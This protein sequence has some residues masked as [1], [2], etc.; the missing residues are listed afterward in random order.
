MVL[1]GLTT[2]DHISAYLGHV[3]GEALE[4]ILDLVGQ[5]TSVAEDDG[6]ARLRVFR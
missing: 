3:L 2:V 6:T 4:L 1:D 5:L